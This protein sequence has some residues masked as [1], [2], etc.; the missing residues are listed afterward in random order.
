MNLSDFKLGERLILVS[1]MKN[2]EERRV[3][4]VIAID[5]N[6]NGLVTFGGCDGARLLSQERDRDG[7]RLLDAGQGAFDPTKLGTKPFGLVAVE[8]AEG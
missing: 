8:K 1:R 3:A 4:Y 2:G 6:G 7:S 5:Y